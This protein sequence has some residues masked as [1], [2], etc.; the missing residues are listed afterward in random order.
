MARG[1]RVKMWFFVLILAAVGCYAVASKQGVFGSNLT[2][3]LESLIVSKAKEWKLSPALVKAHARVESNFNPMAKNPSDPSYGLM[4][5][6]PALAY[7]YGLIT[8]YISPSELEVE[9]IFN[10]DNNLSIACWFMSR[11]HSRYGFDQ[12]VQSYNVGEGCLLYT[13]PSPRD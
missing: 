13:S 7:D 2:P 12:A 6:T 11:L 9:M 5:I 10:I 8:N 3:E 4:Q 1:K